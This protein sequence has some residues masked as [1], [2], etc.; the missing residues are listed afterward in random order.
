MRPVCHPAGRISSRFDDWIQIYGMI[1]HTSAIVFKAIDYGET[2]KI[3]TLFTE[4]HGKIAVIVKGA[5]KPKNKFAGLMEVGSILEVIYYHKTTRSV[6][7]LTEASIEDKTLGLR[8]DFEKMALAVSSI[9][10]IGQL[11]HENEV[12]RPVFEFTRK[13]LV[14]LNDCDISP[15]KIF[16]Y[17]QV[18][19]AYLAGIGLQLE[20]NGKGESGPYYLDLESGHIAAEHTSGS[21]IFK[22]TPL[23]AEYLILTLQGRGTRVFELSFEPGE[24]KELIE[25]LD[26]YFKY[27]VEGIRDRR[28]DAIFEQMMQ[29]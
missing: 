8:T 14:W 28:S 15:G 20:I 13:F 16:P 23:Q 5:K 11:L 3:V 27:H 29:D 21:N 17:L 26:R 12:N 10:L 4:E 24:L 1:V 22:L 7:I 6:Q 2:S 25:L 18:R 9:E 19:L